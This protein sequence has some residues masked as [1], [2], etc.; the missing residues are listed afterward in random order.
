MRRFSLILGLVFLLA[1]ALQA[2]AQS[3]SADVAHLHVQLIFPSSDLYSGGHGQTGNQAGLYFKL[4]PGWHV[5]WR[6]PGDSGE[7]PHIH[8]TL[9]SGLTASP[10]QFPAP[11]RLPLGPLMDFGYEDEVLFPFRFDV[12]KVAKPGTAA[13]ACQGGLAGLPRSLHSGQG[14]VGRKCS[15]TS[16]RTAGQADLAG[17]SGALETPFKFTPSSSPVRRP[18]HL[19]AHACR[20]SSCCRN[21]TAGNAGRVLSRRPGHSRQPRAANAHAHGQRA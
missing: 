3:N 21:R 9:P 10:M 15:A 19:P 8:W 17:G 1:A 5:Y 6:N 4:E 14:G 2:A 16:R 11:K 12:A 20:V 13:P 7:P 18:C